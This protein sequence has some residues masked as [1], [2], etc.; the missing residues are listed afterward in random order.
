[1]ATEK[2]LIKQLFKIAENQQKI[3]NKLA[4]FD[5]DPVPS[6][7]PA[8]LDLTPDSPTKKEAAAILNALQPAVRAAVAALEVHPAMGANEVKV[9]FVQGKGTSAVFNAIQATVQDLQSKNVLGGQSYK[10]VQVN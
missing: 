5:V 3:I 7:L 4:G 2:D 6:L 9:K 8:P 10:I 1:M